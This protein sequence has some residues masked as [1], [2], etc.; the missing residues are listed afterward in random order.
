VAAFVV[1]LIAGLGAI[2]L[3]VGPNSALDMLLAATVLTGLLVA[4]AQPMP[5]FVAARPFADATSGDDVS[6]LMSPFKMPI[7]HGNLA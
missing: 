4:L 6:K 3:A 2:V 1:A 5:A 7:T